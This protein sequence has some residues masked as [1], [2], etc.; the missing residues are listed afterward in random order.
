MC[1][2][3]G[4]GGNDG[5]D[6]DD[7]DV[8]LRPWALQTLFFGSRANVG[9]RDL[10]KARLDARGQITKHDLCHTARVA[11][12]LGALWPEL[13]IAETDGALERAHH[14]AQADVRG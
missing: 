13:A 10:V 7:I 1:G 3:S 6:S 4:S 14:I 5:W 9:N 12:W 11:R 8:P 2:C